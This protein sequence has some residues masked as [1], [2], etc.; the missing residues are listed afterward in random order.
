MTPV[1]VVV[2][3][4]LPVVV[5]DVALPP[6]PQLVMPNVNTAAM[7]TNSAPRNLRRRIPQS[8]SSPPESAA[9]TMPR[10]GEAVPAVVG[11]IDAAALLMGMAPVLE[12]VDTVFTVSVADWVAFAARVTGV[13]ERQ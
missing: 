8:A 11:E 2:V 5:V 3:P 13:M 6:P 7:R 12:Q 10:C 9:R 1:V 4:P